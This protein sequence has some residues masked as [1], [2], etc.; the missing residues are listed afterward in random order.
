MTFDPYALCPGGRNKKIR[1]CCPDMLKELE[2]IQKFFADE[3]FS[4]CY[5]YIEEIEKKHPD[6]ACLDSA[7]LEILKRQ[8]RW[9]EMHALA[10]VFHRREPENPSALADLALAHAA[11]G[12]ADDALSFLVD[13][14]ELEEQGKVQDK[15]LLATQMIC[16]IFAQTG[17]PTSGLALSKVLLAYFPGS[18]EMAQFLRDLIMNTTLPTAIKALRFNP[19]APEGFSGK[20]DYDMIAPLVVTGRWKNAM[21]DLKRL[22]G[23]A[24]EWPEILVSLALL[25]LW[26]HKMQDAFE[27]IR[28][29][30]GMENVSDEDKA[31]IMAVYYML[32]RRNLNDETRTVGW[33]I[34]ISDYDATLEQLLSTPDLYAIDFDPR[35]YGDADHPA[36]KKIFMVL[37]GPFPEDGVT[38]TI[39]NTPRQLGTLLLFG[40]QTD[41]EARLEVVEVL[42]SEQ[43]NITNRLRDKIGNFIVKVGETR[44]LRAISETAAQIDS[45]LRFKNSNSPSR[46]Q[47]FQLVE[48][49]LTLNGPFWQWWL[50]HPFAV[51]DGKT[52]QETAGDPAYKVKILGMIL[53]VEYLLPPRDSLRYCNSVREHLGFSP[54]GT[55]SLPEE[56]PE[57]AV[58]KLPI[59]RWHR[60]D[61]T[62]LSMDALGSELGMLDLVGESRGAIH[63][64][65]A[66]LEKPLVE[67]DYPIRALA[68]R[69]LL[70]NAEDRDDYDDALLW[71]ERAKNEVM[72]L[73]LYRSIAEWD[74]AELMVRIKQ[75]N[76]SETSRLID[77]IMRAHRDNPQAMM[78]MQQLFIQLG[79]INPDGTPTEFARRAPRRQA[80]APTPDQQPARESKLWTPDGSSDSSGGGSSGLWTPDME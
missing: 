14:F 66:I 1:F 67:A 19:S 59:T 52:P 80:V 27:T 22:A 2:K 47:L 34:E 56:Q 63:F 45:R 17:Y 50:H 9:E 20:E 37:N 18:D 62:P 35:R 75:R 7:K 71:I 69:V 55:I 26:F 8:N 73:K 43:E 38:P 46:E 23:K 53:V 36:P 77:Y 72:E 10:E 51:L 29:Y 24:S 58:S 70:N 28:K 79:L 48:D 44:G 42:E 40:R 30:I 15:V 49:S 32:D 57:F 4:A 60:L 74:I 41:R 39:E 31:D 11:L 68:F 65:K 3:Q 25:Q 13:A 61:T 6:C 5:S 76:Q 78:A 64:A 33:D 12:N 21:T 54:L 16:Q